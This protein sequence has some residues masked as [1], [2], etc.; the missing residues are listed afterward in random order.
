MD[1]LDRHEISNTLFPLTR[2]FKATCENL[3][4]SCIGSKGALP[5]KY[6]AAQWCF[7]STMCNVFSWKNTFYGL[8]DVDLFQQ[9]L[10]LFTFPLFYLFLPLSGQHPSPTF[11]FVEHHLFL[12]LQHFHSLDLRSL[13]EHFPC[14]HQDHWGSLCHWYVLWSLLYCSGKAPSMSCIAEGWSNEHW[15]SRDSFNVRDDI[16]IPSIKTAIYKY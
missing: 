9:V 14:H 8:F 15:M 13:W 4:T 3:G 10:I 7:L 5:G 12:V 1:C 6:F 11:V 2:E 16:N